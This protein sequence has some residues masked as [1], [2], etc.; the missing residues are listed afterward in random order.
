MTVIYTPHISPRLQY[1]VAHLFEGSAGITTSIEEYHDTIGVKINY[2]NTKMIDSE[3]WIIPSGLLQ[4]KNI[5][6]QSIEITYWQQLPVFFSTKGSIPFDIFSAAFYVLSRYEEYLPHEKDPY[7]RY[8]Y[9]NSIAWKYQFLDQ[10]VLDLWMKQ[11]ELVLKQQQSSWH[12]PIR[13]FSIQP[14]Y[15]IDQAYRYLWLS[16]FRN[17][18]GYFFDLFQGQF[19]HIT[20]R[21]KVL[22]GKQKDSYNIYDWL[23]ALHIQYHLDPIYFFLMA[24]KRNSIDKNIDPYTR[25]MQQLIS[26]HA[27]KYTIGI[28]PSAQSNSDI[29]RLKRECQL[30]QYHADQKI[31]RSRQHYVIMDFPD[32]YRRLIQSGILHDYSMG[33]GAVNGFRASIA[34]SFYW[35]DLLNE[36]TTNLR[37]HPFCYMDSTAI[38][39]ERLNA[40]MAMERMSGLYETVKK[41]N[42][43]FSFI[44]HNHFLAEQSEWMIWRQ[45]YEDFLKKYC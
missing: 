1:I 36:Q 19:D 8:A 9:T 43:T 33:Y 23:D 31:E 11:L 24:E 35:Y 41:V 28:H 18:R 7:G 10:P 15:D 38:F 3:L 6:D 37:I 27:G 14:T 25:G 40:E 21:M 34:H 4:E 29:D 12:L 5:R 22:S 39:H 44:L 45:L 42:G 16:P 20:T 2:S 30:L 26:R 32:T 17:I 13:I